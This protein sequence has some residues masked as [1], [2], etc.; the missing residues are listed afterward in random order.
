MSGQKQRMAETY[1]HVATSP[2]MLRI[3]YQG[4]WW[5]LTDRGKESI[6]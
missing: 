5:T 4:E 2:Y 3:V 1:Y 6:S